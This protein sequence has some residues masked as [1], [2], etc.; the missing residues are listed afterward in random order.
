LRITEG[1]ST[2]IAQAITNYV[3]AWPR[4][5]RQALNCVARTCHDALAKL[6][7]DHCARFLAHKQAEAYALLGEK[8]A[9]LNTW[10]TYRHYFGSN[11]SQQEFFPDTHLLADIP[12]MAHTLRQG[13]SAQYRKLLRELRWRRATGGSYPDIPWW[14]ILLFLWGILQLV[15]AVVDAQ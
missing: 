13:S 6:P 7:H 10:D 12:A 15:R 9:F 2:R 1:P 5:T 4:G 14:A 11:L 8:E 3:L